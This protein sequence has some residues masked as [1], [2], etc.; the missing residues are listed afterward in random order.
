MASWT[1]VAV[2][3]GN[4]EEA[5][6]LWVDTFGFELL[7]RRDGNDPELARLW[8]LAADDI[9]R[10]AL[11]RT[12]E[13]QVGMIH[14]VQFNDPAPPVRRNA[15]VFDLCPKN[16]DIYVRDLPAR[17]RELLAA[18]RAFRTETYSEVTAPN[19]IRFREIHMPSHDNI[20][21]VLL[22]LIGEDFAFT[23]KGYAGVGP[24]ITIVGDAE[25]EKYF[26]QDIIGLEIL[27]NNILDG[28]D[29]EKMI[30]LPPG[31]ALDVSIWGEKESHLGQIEIIDYRGVEGT[32]LYPR[33]KPKSLGILHVSYTVRDLGK[34]QDRLEQAG[35]DFSRHGR[36]NILPASGEA[37]HFYSPAGLRIE[38]FSE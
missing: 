29:I 13:E 19:G 21:V 25:K 26:Y 17:H 2:G 38:V 34:F 22:E 32:D 4:M 9:A 10:Q 11:V 31:S 1:S 3:V 12:P 35:L 20:N 36:V 5:L 24:V 18:G 15:Q 30:G 14:L 16:L 28:P 6:E 27:S 7:S 37:I 33:A 23:E 8:N